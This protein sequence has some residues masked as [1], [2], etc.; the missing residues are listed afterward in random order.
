MK[1]RTLLMKV[2][3]PL[4]AA[5]VSAL[6]Y[7]CLPPLPDNVEDYDLIYTTWDEDYNFGAVQTYHLPNY[8]AHLIPEGQNPNT[9]FDDEILETL[10]DNL[11]ALGWTR[12]V[13]ADTTTADIV[14][15]SAVF[16]QDNTTCYAWWD[17]W[18]YWWG[19]YPPYPGYGYPGYVSCSSFKTGTLIVQMV[20]RSIEA[21]DNELPIYWLGALNGLV[22]GNNQSIAQRIKSSIDQMF[23]QSPYL[24]N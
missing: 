12:A 4:L 1:N 7:G 5:F 13:G 17:Y 16:G 2:R 21:G 22:E 6:L 8:V 18:G 19:Y 3:L 23:E 10:E 11:N 24:N 9:T 20:D 15:T 14:V